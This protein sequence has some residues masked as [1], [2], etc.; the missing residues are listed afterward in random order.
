M[1]THADLR[2]R[3]HGARV[4]VDGAD[5]KASKGAVVIPAGTSDKYGQ[6]HVE[7]VGN[8]G[9]DDIAEPIAVLRA[10]DRHALPT[11]RTYFAAM[12]MD[13][14]VPETQIASVQRQIAAFEE[15]RIAH[16]EKVRTPGTTR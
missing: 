4:A 6:V 16:P 9:F 11:M 3:V 8:T 5:R 2:G 7:R 12:L 15:W 10:Q 1:A 14:Q 13:E